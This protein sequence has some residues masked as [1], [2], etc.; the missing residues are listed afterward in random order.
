MDICVDTVSSQAV[1]LNS[2]NSFLVKLKFLIL[3]KSSVL[4]FSFIVSV[5]S[6]LFKKSRPTPNLDVPDG[7]RWCQ[8]KVVAKSSISGA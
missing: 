3:I 7:A 4:I 1:P 6:A 8:L 2:L 5:F